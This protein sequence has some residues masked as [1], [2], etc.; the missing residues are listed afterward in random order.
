VIETNLS[1]NAPRSPG[2]ARVVSRLRGGGF[3][4]LFRSSRLRT[5]NRFANRQN[6]CLSRRSPLD[7]P[8]DRSVG[9]ARCGQGY[10]PVLGPQTINQSALPGAQHLLRQREKIAERPH[11]RRALREI[12][13]YVS[14][15]DRRVHFKNAIGEFFNP[16]D[17]A[18][19]G[20]TANSAFALKRAIIAPGTGHWEAVFLS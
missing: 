7:S 4:A 10:E 17:L 9:C 1:L 18:N 11:Q 20:K 19:L 2:G 14:R 12:R 5:G 3:P 15:P 13:L 16:H 6:L 8:D